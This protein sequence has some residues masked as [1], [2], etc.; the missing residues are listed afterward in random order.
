MSETRWTF[1]PRKAKKKKGKKTVGESP[2]APALKKLSGRIRTKN[3]RARQAVLRQ[4]EKL[5]KKY[6]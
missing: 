5:S 1:S 3:E 2:G 4:L 6:K